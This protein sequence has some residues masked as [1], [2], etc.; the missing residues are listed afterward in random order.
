M[1]D[2]KTSVAIHVGKNLRPKR[3]LSIRGFV[4]FDSIPEWD[5][6]EALRKLTQDCSAGAAIMTT[7][8]FKG[9]SS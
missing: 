9:E 2:S 4:P 8:F 3:A 5:N 7:S 1:M 6:S